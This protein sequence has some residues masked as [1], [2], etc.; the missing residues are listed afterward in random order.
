MSFTV[1][2]KRILTK[3]D[4]EEFQSSDA[5]ND[6]MGFIER[7]NESVKGLKIDS[8]IEVS[9]VS[10]PV[11]IAENHF[12][13][14][15]YSRFFS[16]FKKSVEKVLS[17]LDALLQTKAEI[18]P[19]DNALSRFGNPAFVTFYDKAAEVSTGRLRIDEFIATKLMTIY[20]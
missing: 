14:T 7:L 4:L 13:T 19:V 9:P 5:Y 12:E 11:A 15:L 8:E 20:S 18:P 3:E 1:P 17:L 16:F 2:Q 10:L 6:F